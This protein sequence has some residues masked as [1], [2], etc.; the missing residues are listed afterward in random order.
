L[1]AFLVF[2]QESLGKILLLQELD[3]Y[4]EVNN[5]QNYFVPAKS[6]GNLKKSLKE[7]KIYLA[8]PI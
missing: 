5:R 8:R 1:I 2:L 7:V 3:E 6:L 4:V